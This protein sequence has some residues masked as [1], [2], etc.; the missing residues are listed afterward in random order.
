MFLDIFFEVNS[1]RFVN[2]F[3]VTFWLFFLCV[4]TLLLWVSIELL[5]VERSFIYSI[6]YDA[7]KKQTF[8]QQYIAPSCESFKYSSIINIKEIFTN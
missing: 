2:V 1:E 3:L 6:S 7:Q 8:N 4:Q 5:N